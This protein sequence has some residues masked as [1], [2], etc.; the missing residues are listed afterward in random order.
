MEIPKTYSPKDFEDD[1]YKD[2]EAQELFNPDKIKPRRKEHFSIVL[3]P[4]NV[5]G[6]LHL[7]HA[8]MLA[9]EDLFVRYKRMQGFDTAWIPGTDHAAIATQ[10]VVE[11][12]L[13][14]EEGKTRHDLGRERFLERVEAYVEDSKNIIH[15]QI[16]KM[17]ASL[18]W[19]REAYTLDETRARAV[20]KV[21]K[22]M[23]DDGLIYRGYRIVN[24]CPR[25]KTTL[26]DDEVDYK[27]QSAKL[28]T[29]KYDKNFPFAIAT[30]RPETK[31]GDAAVAVNPNDERYQ[32]YIGQIFDVNFCGVDLKIKIIADDAVE[33]E[34]GT[35]ALGVT[36]AH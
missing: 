31:L 20:R 3:P 10:N 4:P 19:S 2:W 8:S 1:I 11:K 13:W 6:T 14:K 30:T 22:M 29:F 24:W 7:G 34:F 18:D 5:T 25:C 17:G 33:S 27:E 32:E 15:N 12:K 23:Y 28:Y 26:A 36:P 21:F 16:R 35:G 9:I